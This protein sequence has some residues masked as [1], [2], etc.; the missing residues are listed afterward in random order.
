MSKETEATSHIPYSP[1]NLEKHVQR[2]SR[3][4][5]ARNFSNL[6]ILNTVAE[7]IAEE[8]DKAGANVEFQEFEVEGEIYKNVRGL[9]GPDSGERIVLGAHYD[10]CGDTPGAD[11]NASAV[12]GLIALAHMLGKKDTFTKTIECVA[13][14][15]EEPPF[16][17]TEYMGSFKHA[18]LLRKN[19]IQLR[20]MICLEMIG[21]FCDEKNS[22]D[23]PIP[24]MKFL[25]PSKGNFIAV[26]GRL[27][28]S[29][30]VESVS[31]SMKDAT[32]LPVEHLAAPSIVPGIA[33]SDHWSYWQHN[34][35]AVMITDTSF[36]RNHNY[37]EYT[38]TP[39]TLD[40]HRMSKVVEGVYAAIRSLLA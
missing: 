33:F 19:H 12:A 23:Y 5:P 30:L 2:L 38:D 28:D 31:Q 40:Y 32:D 18:E 10:V 9:F 35:H 17:C 7:Y 4:N 25:Y 8:F 21:Y 6:K 27:A 11:D 16:F 3:V 15:L 20:A 24:G 39:D 36:Y 34:Y 1:E 29:K 22:Q 26:V 37:H 14:T 13:Y